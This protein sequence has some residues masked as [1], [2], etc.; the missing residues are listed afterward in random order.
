MA[1]YLI[2]RHTLAHIEPTVN[3]GTIAAGFPEGNASSLD[4]NFRV[5]WS[6]AALSLIW[7]R[8]AASLQGFNALMLYGHSVS[9]GTHRVYADA[10]TT[11]TTAMYNA[12][13]IS[14]LDPIVYVWNDTTLNTSRYVR[15]DLSATSG[16][17]GV[18]SVCRAYNLGKAYLSLNHSAVASGSAFT[19][20]PSGMW[21]GNGIGFGSGVVNA[22]FGPIAA[23]TL[24]SIAD[25]TGQTGGLK[26]VRSLLY[27]VGGAG[28]RHPIALW[29][30]TN[31]RLYYGVG[32]PTVTETMPNYGDVTVSITEWPLAAVL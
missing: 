31:S 16:T 23:S 12:Q 9:S 1:W 25:D 21:I 13:S 6:G 4:P 22:S 18:I 2:T 5:K 17:A 7:D 29:D 28:G 27:A 24:R 20:S 10:N 11:P 3:T 19:P 8:G 32:Q 30:G 15:V 26:S 14:S